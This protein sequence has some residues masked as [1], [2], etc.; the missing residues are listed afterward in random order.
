[1]SYYEEKHTISV[2]DQD[3]L[4]KFERKY[5]RPV[6]HHKNIQI[7][8][9]DSEVLCTDCNTKLNPVHWIAKH[10]K[11]LNQVTARN[12]RM[13]SEARE[14]QNKLEKKNKFM[15]KHCHEVNVIDFKKLP[16]QAAVE[17][18]MEV[19]T[20]EFDGFAVEIVK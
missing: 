7:S 17:R 2:N 4:I 15:C 10:L 14:I 5:D 8:E 20:T 3:Q 19:I 16:S 18:G 9:Q 12:N 6:C 11:Q 1:M 13:L